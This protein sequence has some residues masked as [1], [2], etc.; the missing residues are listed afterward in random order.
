MT[1]LSLLRSSVSIS[2]CSN[3]PSQCQRVTRSQTGMRRS[4]GTPPG[5]VLST[6]H[7]KNSHTSQEVADSTNHIQRLPAE[8]LYTVL[9][10]VIDRAAGGA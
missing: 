8:I 1:G 3:M 7:H 5:F 10:L 2:L 9:K 6:S 4:L